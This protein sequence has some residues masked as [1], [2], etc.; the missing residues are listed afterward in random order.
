MVV[1]SRLH[2]HGMA[3]GYPVNGRL[4]LAV[5]RRIAAAC[6]RIVGAADFG[7]RA[8]RRIL[9]EP[10]TGHDVPVAQ[11]DLIAR[12]QPIILR[13]RH[14]PE[15]ILLDVE[16]SGERDETRSRRG[17]LGV[18]HRL[19]LLH[20]AGGPVLD[21]ELHRMEHGH[22]TA[23]AA[24]QVLPEA[25]LE[26]RDLH[27]AHRLGHAHAGDE[28]TDRLGRVAASA[29]AHQRRHAGIVPPP[30]PPLLHELQQPAL[31][32]HRV[33]EVESG[34]LDLPAVEDPEVLQEPVVE[35]AMDLV[36]LAAQRMRH[37]LDGV[38]ERVLVVVHRIDA[39]CVPRAMMRRVAYAVHHGVPHV[40]IGVCHVDLR[41]QR[42]RPV[43][44]LPRAH[45]AEEAEVLRD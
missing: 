34:E 43:G 4:H 25:M 24:V 12:V 28:I 36:L 45:P 6:G 26:K 19:Q 18:V 2:L 33:G 5:V 35:R 3:G 17:V 21:D 39:P 10:G 16:L 11:P 9:R 20:L 14:F 32:H 1:Q 7:D 22:R 41:A 44:E 31:A 42:A 29:Q 30:D 23:A 8:G 27:R 15:I 37:P 13:R 38:G 40:E